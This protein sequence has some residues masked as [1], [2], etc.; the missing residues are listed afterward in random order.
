MS[1]C[2]QYV[3]LDLIDIETERS[4][5]DKIKESKGIDAMYKVFIRG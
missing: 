4:P 3:L 2:R 5:F 1:K